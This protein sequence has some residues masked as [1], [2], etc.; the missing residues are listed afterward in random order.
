MLAK[1]RWGVAGLLLGWAALAQAVYVDNFSP[2]GPVRTA[3]HFTARFSDAMVKLGQTNAPAPFEVKC[4]AA[5]QGRWSDPSTWQYDLSRPL[6]DGERCDFN[7]KP[8]FKSLKGEKFYNYGERSASYSVQTLGPWIKRVQPSVGGKVDEDQAFILDVSDVV[9]AQSLEGHAWCEAEGV[10]E[11]IPL[12]VL[13]RTELGKLVKKLHITL[14]TTGV[15]LLVQ[16]ARPL[17]AGAK[18]KLVWGRGIESAKGVKLLDDSVYTFQ[19][20]A[21]FTAHL[22]C[23]RERPNMP[24]SPLSNLWLEFTDQIHTDL[25]KGIRLVGKKGEQKPEDWSAE[26]KAAREKAG[27][28]VQAL[29]EKGGNNHVDR[30]TFK[31]PFP[32]DA[33]FTVVLPK[34]FQDMSGRPLKNAAQFPLKTRV[35]HY[36]PLAKFAAGFGILELKEGGLLPITVRNVEANLKMRVLRENTD[37]GLLK[38]W[39]EMEKFESQSGPEVKKAKSGD[40]EETN[41]YDRYYPREV[42]YLANRREAV[43]QTLPKPNGSLP[44]EVMAIPLPKPGFYVVEV[45]SQMLGASLLS[46]PKPMYV[47]T[48]ALVTDMSVH[49][50]K[51]RDNSLVWV[52][53]LST[54]KPVAGADVS[55]YDC[56]QKL[57][58]RGKTDSQGR[59]LLDGALRDEKAEYCDD[60]VV[61]ARAG[62]DFS[63]VRSSWDKGI[64]PWRFNLPSWD[65]IS[66]PKIHTVLDRSL[67]RVGETVSMKHIARLPKAHGFSYPNPKNLPKQLTLRRYGGED[68]VVIP[69]VWDARGVAIT[70]WKIPAAAK[71]GTYTIDMGD[72]MSSGEFRVAEFRLPKYKGAVQ[73]E[74]VSHTDK[75]PTRLSLEYLNGGSAGGQK[76][77]LSAQLSTAYPSFPRYREYNFDRNSE[78][79]EPIAEQLVLDKR[80]LVLDKQGAARLDIPLLKK[81]TRPMSLRSEMTF[82]DPNGEVQTIAGSVDVWP[83]EVLVGALVK[84]EEDADRSLEIIALDRSGKPRAGVSVRATGKHHWE[85]VHRKRILGGFYSYESESHDDDLGVVCDGKTNAEGKLSCPLTA[86]QAGQINILV[87]AEDGKGGVSLAGT[88]YYNARAGDFW[89]D[90]ADQDRMDVVPERK[91]YQPGDMAR[92]RVETPFHDATALISIE[93]E[94]I[95]ETLVRPLR[96]EDPVV[97]MRVGENWG[98][99]VFV[100]VMVVRGRVAEVPWYS[101]FQWGWRK[102]T[103]WWAAWRA[104]QQE[105]APPTAMVDLS[106]PAFKLGITRLD[107]GM[108]GAR[109][110]VDVNADK[111]V[112]APRGQATVKVRVRLPNGQP[113]PAGSEVMLAAVDKALLELAANPSWNLLEDMMQER[114]YLVETSTAQM[115]VVGKRH[116]GKKALPAGG[117]GGRASSRELFDTLLYW[118]PRVKLDAQGMATVQFPLNDSLTTFKIVAVADV[119]EGYFG[120]GATEIRSTQDVQIIA[121]V[122]PLVREGDRYQAMLTVRNTTRAPMTLRL[123]GTAGKQTLP[124]LSVKLAA[125][126]ASELNWSVVVPSQLAELPWQLKAVDDKGKVRD[127]LKFTQKIQPRVPVTVQ[128]ATFLRLEQPY[129]VPVAL[130]DGALPNLGGVDVKL[131]AKLA[132]QT[133]GIR[134]Y[135]QAYP[136]SCLEQK[137]SVASGLHD[138]Q[139]WA[140]IVQNLVGYL[141]ERGLAQYFPGA[142][143]GSETLSAYVLVMAQENGIALPEAVD[144]KLQKGLLDFAEGRGKQAS[145]A[146]GGGNYLLERRLHVLEA[147]AHRGKVT[148]RMLTAF[149]FTPN[150]MPIASLVDWYSLLHRVPDAPQRVERL[151]QLEREVRNRMTYSGG[152][153]MFTGE[154]QEDWW[155]MMLNGE[156]N[157]LR[158]LNEVMDDP[159]WQKDLPALLR[160]ALLRQQRG[161]WGTT[162]ANVW[163]DLALQKFSRKFERDTVAGTTTAQLGGKTV[164]YAWNKPSD[165]PL[166][167]PWGDGKGAFSLTHQGSG[168]PWATVLVQAAV[169]GKLVESGYRIKRTVK[170]IEQKVAGQ[171]SRGDLLRVRV[172][173]EAGQMM[174]WVALSDPIPSGASILGNTERDSQIGQQGENQTKDAEKD[175]N[176]A[177]PIATERGLG[178]FRAYYEFT[179]K[180]RFWFEYT[181]RLN[182]AGEFFLPPSRVEAM[183]APE[184]FGQ[185]PNGM[186]MVK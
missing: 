31:G 163:G 171:W 129:R 95:V 179:P 93:R 66:S 55:V 44:F 70:Q 52:T 4:P 71:L 166:S 2:Q 8:N 170:A 69:L 10:G 145:N 107:V 159:A 21:P 94:G 38:V 15:S 30:V 90:Q 147:L 87:Q 43:A 181:L 127:S 51:G 23:E 88:S 39:A 14:P 47:R 112:Y 134:Q 1:W 102:P 142:G 143:R 155:W 175:A 132:G 172:E 83:A 42:S 49:F 151:A 123:Q 86:K 35:T 59:A 101:F 174:N 29:D 148:G 68:D 116:F 183:Y 46:T 80:A 76:V 137:I 65:S 37:S 13:P 41:R 25:A 185:T 128:Q 19:V 156:S 177:W 99:N 118:N 182:N 58:K 178:Y 133:E 150:K 75:V 64:E 117:G 98:P 54:G 104:N 77:Q 20:R 186:W 153:L 56:K 24:C 114:G 11:R 85:F 33:E 111:A 139:R 63:F 34:N 81:V 173:V 48:Q 110:L 53:A 5:G 92:F 9:N 72:W 12:T 57:L 141:D 161:H 73:M 89:F 61:T 103:V 124:E 140:E 17:P 125:D 136:Y 32:P 157:V 40:E 50:K 28:P 113:A 91:D 3:Q 180:G 105:A 106:R 22:G 67:F 16:C 45:E 160:G 184:L 131:S 60:F 152:R 78:E 149:D 122:P 162:V 26:F 62:E 119:N 154:A 176:H 27:Q 165:A 130:P 168:Q 167:L 100:S 84:R 126:E 138:A 36:P 164:Q 146:F 6:G 18:M 108:K 121:A 82:N 135:F 115:Q 158:L 120:T 144:I 109:L 79:E 169:P 97:E 96:R 74:A 7:L